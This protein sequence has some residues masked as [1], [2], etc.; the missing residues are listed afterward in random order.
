M[1]SP[2]GTPS[3]T[4]ILQRKV[5]KFQRPVCEKCIYTEKAHFVE[6]KTQIMQHILKMQQSFLFPKYIKHISRGALLY[7]FAYVN[8]GL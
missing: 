6:N 7:V 8:V 5:L 1:G 4:L 2:S 3:L